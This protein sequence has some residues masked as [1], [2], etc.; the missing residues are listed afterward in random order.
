MSAACRGQREEVEQMKN[1]LRVLSQPVPSPAGEADLAIDQQ[2]REAALELLADLC[3]NM[4]N[5]AGTAWLPLSLGG[6]PLL[7][8]GPPLSWLLLSSRPHELRLYPHPLS[9]LPLSNLPA[10]SS[11]EW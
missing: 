8:P 10:S 1:C 5:A 4:D 11:M 7:P 9:W 3:E 6:L 2:E